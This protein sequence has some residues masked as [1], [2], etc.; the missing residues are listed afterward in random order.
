MKMSV[1]VRVTLKS[2]LAAS[3]LG[4][5]ILG[6]SI[7]ST[8]A[9]AAGKGPETAQEV[10]AFA[11]E[12][13]KRPEIQSKLT[14]AAFVVVSGDKVL[15]NKGFGYANLENK[16]PIK[17]DETVFRMASITK[18]FTAA[19]VMQL[20][21]EG[22]VDLEGEVAP[23]LKGV[24]IPNQTGSPLKVKHLLTHTTGFDF[25][26][27]LLPNS[28]DLSKTSSLEGFIKDWMPS[29]V[30]TP[31]EA[32][33]YDNFASD[34]QGYLVQSVTG[35][36][37][38]KVVRDRIFKPLHMNHSSFEIGK[39]D[40]KQ[41]ATG[42]DSNNKPISPY[43]FTPTISPAGGMLAT[44]S[45]IAQFMLAQLNGGKLGSSTILKPE[46]VANMQKVHVGISPE[47]PNM[48][49]GFEMFYQKYY[50]GQNVVGKSGDL[51]G[52][53][54]Y[55]WLLPDKKV[56]GF[57]VTNGEA[58]DVRTDLFK[59]FMD[60]YYP[61]DGK[62]A[63]ELHSTKQEL[64]RFEGSFR[65]LRIPML[66]FDVKLEDDHLILTTPLGDVKLKQIGK[67]LFQDE[68]GRLAAFKEDNKGNITHLYYLLPDAWSERIPKTE[69]YS[70]VKPDSPYAA[71]IQD[72][73]KRRIMKNTS[74]TFEPQRPIT[75]GEFCAELVGLIGI[76]PSVNPVQF[77]DV[78]GHLYAPQ[79]QMLAEFGAATGTAQGKFEPDR[80]ITRQEAAQLVM[81]TFQI[82]VHSPVKAKLSGETD[83]W[84]IEAV[85]F[86]AG[87][88]LYGPEVKQE[89]DG[90][91]NY[92]SRDVMLRQEAAA[93][94]TK[95]VPFLLVEMTKG[96]NL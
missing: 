19:A 38:E 54:S 87:A 86:V 95:A 85:Q 58:V 63:V 74:S 55:M 91:V 40:L 92:R 53:H 96:K 73:Q 22:K 9:A 30:R 81:K 52:Y 25:T 44:S 5:S 36:S 43:T 28:T 34:L 24:K 83:P 50:N 29:V 11:D 13:F 84:A 82:F 71:F 47:L 66:I 94:L 46:T 14:G 59:A 90:S 17:P 10:E 64:A 60:R 15:L 67:L 1:P 7:K 62:P 41:L 76:K 33:R 75:R 8:A 69:N 23:Y 88:G 77:N 80:A 89:A 48:G 45:D 32:Y 6:G 21:E 57:V 51:P 4:A 72:L 26:D 27:N 3:V 79:I 68:N 12:F 39:L 16:Q 93:L 61:A 2:F 31:G 20:V 49:Y 42:Y 70:D 65:Y 37:F 35:Q 56:G 78:Q 18:V